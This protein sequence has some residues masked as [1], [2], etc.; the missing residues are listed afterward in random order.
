LDLIALA[1]AVLFMGAAG[2]AGVDAPRSDF[3]PLDMI[4]FTFLPALA[5]VLLGAF[6]GYLAPKTQRAVAVLMIAGL[7]II[8]VALFNLIQPVDATRIVGVAYLIPAVC[9]LGASILVLR[10][11]AIDKQP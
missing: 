6:G 7:G 11:R 8:A 2:M 9:F 5:C 1:I 4:A 10:R 3:S